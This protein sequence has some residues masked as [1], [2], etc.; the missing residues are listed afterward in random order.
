M[1]STGEL[2]FAIFRLTG[3]KVVSIRSIRP[4]SSESCSEFVL[5]LQTVKASF[6]EM[7]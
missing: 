3:F 7:F 5:K 1:A 2:P 6:P 4:D